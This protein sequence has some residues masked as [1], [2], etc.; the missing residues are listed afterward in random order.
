MFLYIQA[1]VH[2]CEC[3]IMCLLYVSVCV[4]AHLHL[5]GLET[6]SLLTLV[7]GDADVFK[8]VVVKS[9]DTDVL[10]QFSMLSG[11]CWLVSCGFNVSSHCRGPAQIV[12]LA[13]FFRLCSSQ[14]PLNWFIVLLMETSAEPLSSTVLAHFWK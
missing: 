4:R 6:L 13:A 5:C 8:L 11:S 3:Q 12:V 14:L 10:L 9:E 1:F 7:L 2:N